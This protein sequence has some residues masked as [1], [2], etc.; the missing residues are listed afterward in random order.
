MTIAGARTNAVA[1]AAWPVL[2]VFGP[3][4]AAASSASVS[5]G[6]VAPAAAA[7]VAG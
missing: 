3:A 5:R 1:A 4:L 6:D 2:N 7:V